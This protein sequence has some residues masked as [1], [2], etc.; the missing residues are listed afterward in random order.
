VLW[1]DTYISEVHAEDGPLEILV[2]Y[3]PEDL[4][5][6]LCMSVSGFLFHQSSEVLFLSNTV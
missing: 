3:D 1:L 2:T 5:V 6:L 4:K